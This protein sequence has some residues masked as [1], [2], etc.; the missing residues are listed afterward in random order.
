MGWLEGWRQN[1]LKGTHMSGGWRWLLSGTDVGLWLE[2][3]HV[4]LPYGCS[5]SPRHGGQVPKVSV[6]RESWVEAVSTF[7]T[8]KVTEVTFFPFC[9]SR[10]KEKWTLSLDGQ[11]ASSTRAHGT[12]NTTW[13]FLENTTRPSKSSLYWCDLYYTAAEQRWKTAQHYLAAQLN[14]TIATLPLL[15]KPY[16][17]IVRAVNSYVRSQKNFSIVVLFMLS[18]AMVF[19][20]AFL[21]TV[22]FIIA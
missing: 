3:L 4:A 2:N 1:H 12:G 6:P 19:R 11:V 18:T 7:L 15:W 21:S 16:S 10:N 8:S 20:S 5:S 13:P 22:K 14:V 9:L 17:C